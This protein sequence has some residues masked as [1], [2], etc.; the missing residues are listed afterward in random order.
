M[1]DLEADA[2]AEDLM[3]SYVSGEKGKVCKAGPC[4]GLL[5]DRSRGRLGLASL[6]T[7]ELQEE[8]S[9]SST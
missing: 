8:H 1:D 2:T 6:K 5:V 7:A 3:L 9:K 4:A